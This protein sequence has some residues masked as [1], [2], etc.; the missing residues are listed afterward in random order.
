MFSKN[1]LLI[2]LLLCINLPISAGTLASI[3]DIQHAW[4]TANYQTASEN[5]K[6]AFKNLSEQTLAL[7]KKHPE[8]AAYKVWLAIVLSSD[9]GVN[10]GFSA[11]SKV[12]ESRKWLE[13]AEAIEPKVLDGSI[14]TSLGSLYYKVPGWPIAFG[15]DKKAADYLQKALEINPDGIDPNYFYGDFLIDNNQPEK[16][17]TYLNKAKQAPPRASRPI[18]DKGRLAE[19]E[20]AIKKAQEMLGES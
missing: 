9:A 4:A 13:A 19:I 18:A 11:L 8:Q 5:Q 7:V 2:L 20:L 3:E 12:K 10:G 16:A 6:Q 17:L 1:T 14:Y 15:N